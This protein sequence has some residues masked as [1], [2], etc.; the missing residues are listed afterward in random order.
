MR[1]C[2]RRTDAEDIVQNTFIRVFN[3]LENYRGEKG[4]FG[5]WVHRISV[6][7][8]L[9]VLRKKRPVLFVESDDSNQEEA[10]P[11]P[12][13]TDHLA[14][15]D[16]RKLILKLPEGYRAV[17]NLYAIE[18][19]SHQEIGEQLDITPATSRSQLTRAKRTLK[20]WV[21]AQSLNAS[22]TQMQ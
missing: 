21:V 14:A 22:K 19:Y 15:A 18:G 10:D 4:A 3:Q 13:I 9:R 6:N 11:S 7:E 2:E 5:A 17:F 1:Y 20:Q 16:L 12:L 8:S